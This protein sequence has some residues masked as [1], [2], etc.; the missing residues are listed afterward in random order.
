MNSRKDAFLVRL[1]Q[2]FAQLIYYF[3]CKTIKFKQIGKFPDKR[4]IF[5]FWH[6]SFFP[7]IYMYRNK[8]IHI[9]VS[10]SK[11]GEL[12]IKPLQTFGFVP[13]RGSS[14]KLGDKGLKKMIRVLKNEGYAAITPDGPRGPREVF[15]EGALYI[16]YL[17]KTPI[18]LV[19]VACDKKIE[20]KSWDK[21][22]IPLPFSKC[23][24]FISSPFYIYD[25]KMIEPELFTE[26]LKEVNKIAEKHL[27]KEV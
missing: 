7:L 18:Y 1:T 6:S 21:F 17:S 14:S 24:I 20:L 22:K 8:K 10:L 13:V 2:G 16:S 9:L 15:K 12:L 4:A 25:K 19:G 11:D 27:K 23:L 5:C 3:I 26:F